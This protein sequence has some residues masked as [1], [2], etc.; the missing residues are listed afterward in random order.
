[1]I[2]ATFKQEEADFLLKEFGIKVDSS[3]Q[4]TFTEEKA[5]EI[6]DM[7]EDIEVEE[8]A[9]QDG[10]RRMVRG[11]LACRVHDAII[12]AKRA[13]KHNADISF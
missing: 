10:S 4:Y 12:D 7:C 11:D 3:L 1:M 13:L 9:G 8:Y 2:T 6:E 5:A